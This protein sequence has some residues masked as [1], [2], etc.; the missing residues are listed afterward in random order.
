MS[1]LMTVE[2][3][4]GGNLTDLYTAEMILSWQ[5]VQPAGELHVNIDWGDGIK[6]NACTIIHL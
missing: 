2:R 1:I 6:G 5:F 4:R 3:M